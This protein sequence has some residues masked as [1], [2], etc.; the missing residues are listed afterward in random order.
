MIEKNV[1]FSLRVSLWL[2]GQKA[3]HKLL[4]TTLRFCMLPLLKSNE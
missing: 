1:A 4:V 2:L 3:S